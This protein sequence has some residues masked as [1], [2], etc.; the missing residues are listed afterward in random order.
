MFDEITGD[1]SVADEP[2]ID[3][4]QLDKATVDEYIA[5]VPVLE[6]LAVEH[7]A[8]ELMIDESVVHESETKGTAIHEH[9]VNEYPVEEPMD[10]RTTA[11][12]SMVDQMDVFESEVAESSPDWS[13]IAAHLPNSAMANVS[14]VNTPQAQNFQNGKATP[15]AIMNYT[16]AHPQQSARP[17]IQANG[18]GS[19]KPPKTSPETASQNVSN[20]PEL[21]SQPVRTKYVAAFFRDV[22][23]DDSE[24]SA[25]RLSSSPEEG[26]IPPDENQ[27]DETDFAADR[28]EQANSIDEDMRQVATEALE[29]SR[30]DQTQVHAPVTSPLDVITTEAN[31]V[32]SAAREATV[33][34]GEVAAQTINMPGEKVSRPQAQSTT[35]LPSQTRPSPF[36]G[37]MWANGLPKPRLWTSAGVPTGLLAPQRIELASSPHSVS[38]PDS[39]DMAANAYH[40]PP[41]IPPNRNTSWSPQPMSHWVKTAPQVNGGA[42]HMGD[43][44]QMSR[45]NLSPNQV[46]AKE[47]T[48][49]AMSPRFPSMLHRG[50]RRD[51]E[52][53]TSDLPQDIIARIVRATG[54]ESLRVGA[55]A[56][57]NSRTGRFSCP[58]CTKNPGFERVTR[59][60]NH[61]RRSHGVEAEP[62]WY[63]ASGASQAA[64]TR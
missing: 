14:I 40:L 41:I 58:F 12:K 53:W 35:A 23:C 22:S 18:K 54:K 37:A 36:P 9:A 11:D 49:R 30:D 51:K 48:P 33:E 59:L 64:E 6:E 20:P 46:T 16:E 52:K 61:L 15:E 3:P 4:S 5:D 63:A 60:Q 26:E 38:L 50:F 28:H 13:T 62:T 21:G 32:D 2:V 47:Q 43:G 24:K 44:P 10:D 19:P 39:M 25:R 55:G 29:R 17:E 57:R 1:G 34:V 56:L 8:D 42:P 45:T 7:Q 27:E 31:P